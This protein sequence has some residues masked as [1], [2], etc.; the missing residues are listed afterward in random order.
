MADSLASDYQAICLQARSMTPPFGSEFAKPLWPL[1]AGL[2]ASAACNICQASECHNFATPSCGFCSGCCPDSSCVFCDLHR[3]ASEFL[4]NRHPGEDDDSWERRLLVVKNEAHVDYS[5]FFQAVA[6]GNQIDFAKPISFTAEGVAAAYRQSWDG[7]SPVAPR[8]VVAGDFHEANDHGVSVATTLLL[9]T[10][11]YVLPA[12]LV[13]SYNACSAVRIKRSKFLDRLP[14]VCAVV[15]PD[16]SVPA[17]AASSTR[18]KQSFVVFGDDDAR[19]AHC[20]NSP[21]RLLLHRVAADDR[22]IALLASC[23]CNAPKEGLVERL[24]EKALR[25]PDGKPLMPLQVVLRPSL[26]LSN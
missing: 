12:N 18:T 2:R 13:S 9:S 20:D 26:V 10:P 3:L 15:A 7:S 24:L 23:S 16:D 11:L 19:Q 1:F 5:P 25:N 21:V 22:D 17:G 6:R 4:C 8:L 14:L